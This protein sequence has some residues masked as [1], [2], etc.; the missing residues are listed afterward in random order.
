MSLSMLQKV[1]TGIALSG[2]LVLTAVAVSLAS[3]GGESGVVGV[4]VMPGAIRHDVPEGQDF[5]LEKG[6][7]TIDGQVVDDCGP[8]SADDISAIRILEDGD[9]LCVHATSSFDAWL[10]GEHAAGNEPSE[11]E[12]A[13]MEKAYAGDDLE[14]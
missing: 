5:E 7:V 10:L 4:E 12:R 1:A 13:R 3:E 9:I 11:A 8:Q 2:G 14:P 6:I